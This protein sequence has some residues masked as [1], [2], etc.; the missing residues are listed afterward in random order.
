[1]AKK[2]KAPIP[3]LKNIPLCQAQ[4]ASLLRPPASGYKRL[5]YFLNEFVSSSLCSSV[6]SVAL[7][8][9]VF[10]FFKGVCELVALLLGSQ[11]ARAKTFILKLRN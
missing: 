8:Q 9:T 7:L 4:W 2:I 1:M 5:F 11:F 10:L 3:H 6:S